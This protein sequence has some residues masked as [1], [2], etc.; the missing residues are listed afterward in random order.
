MSYVNK[1]YSSQVSGN[2]LEIKSRET[3]R[4]EAY[5]PLPQFK[6]VDRLEISSLAESISRT[7]QNL[8]E[9]ED[10]I[11]TKFT[12]SAFGKNLSVYANQAKKIARQRLSPPK[13][14]KESRIN[15]QVKDSPKL[16]Q[17]GAKKEKPY[18]NFEATIQ[19]K[20]SNSYF[21]NYVR[22]TYSQENMGKTESQ[23]SY[24]LFY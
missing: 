1:V 18:R 10:D 17:L 8:K 6:G 3:E 13:S 5:K 14:P 20:D 23:P 16:V 2:S 21:N 15:S 22:N 4:A 9:G 19:P 24:S 11:A 7:S 12:K